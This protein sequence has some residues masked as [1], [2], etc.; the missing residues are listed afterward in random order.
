MRSILTGKIMPPTLDP[1][2]TV[3]RSHLIEYLSTD[4]GP[5]ITLVSAPIGYGKSVA[6]AKIASRTAG[7]VAWLTLDQADNDPAR[8]CDYL[9]ASFASAL[10]G[11]NPTAPRDVT[12]DAIASLVIGALASTSDR[13]T[14]I[15]D[16][17]HELSNQVILN[18]IALLASFPPDNFRLV[19]ASRSA[20]DLPVSQW[21]VRGLLR[22]VPLDAMRFTAEE[23][24]QLLSIGAGVRVE[25]DMAER[26]RSWSNGWVAALKM[27]SSSLSLRNTTIAQWSMA[28][29]RADVLDF[30][31]DQF[32][33]RLDRDE[34]D[35][36]TRMS[37]L[38]RFTDELS[39]IVIDEGDAWFSARSLFRRG[40]FI[41]PLDD[42]GEWYRFH[43]ILREALQRRAAE[44]LSSEEIARL[45]RRASAWFGQRGDIESAIDHAIGGNDWTS[46]MAM[47]MPLVEHLASTD[48]L[49]R[50]GEWL[51]TVPEPVI[52]ERAEHAYWYAWTLA[53]LGNVDRA[54]YYCV[55]AERLWQQAG[56]RQMLYAAMSLRA[57]LAFVGGQGRECLE[58]ARK[59]YGQLDSDLVFERQQAHLHIGLGASMSGKAIEAENVLNE[60]I[61]SPT[62][63]PTIRTTA[64]VQAAWVDMMLGHL[65]RAEGRLR[66]VIAERRDRQQ[67]VIRRAYVWL[68]D[69]AIEKERIDEACELLDRADELAEE[70]GTDRPIAD[71]ARRRAKVYLRNGDPVKALESLERQR[72]SH[73][74][75]STP[76][77]SRMQAMRVACWIELG[78]DQQVRQWALER[79]LDQIGN[80]TFSN[81]DQYLAYAR[82]LV[83]K[84]EFRRS[85]EISERLCELAESDGRIGHLLSFLLLRV[86]SEIYLRRESA[87]QTARRALQIAE[88]GG[89]AAT[90][91]ISDPDVN[92][93]LT[94]LRELRTDDSVADRIDR[95]VLTQRELEVLRLVAVGHSNQEIAEQLNVATA[96]VK[97]HVANVFVKLNVS[98]RTEAVYMARQLL[99]V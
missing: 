30:L 4:D 73:S 10:P 86:R 17:A 80:L 70:F 7:R 95:V 79:Q 60:L 16:D 43:P 24:A 21:R 32:I 22:E 62:T 64:R 88:D 92:A 78:W 44:S 90:I 39:R 71:T 93:L 53:G 59:S 12:A 5:T 74:G 8:F 47:M 48:R 19:L 34:I 67:D 87:E 69:I 28:S 57:W 66:S 58:L 55:Q 77:D 68:A 72:T 11:F 52:L 75:S 9:I 51:A 46:A 81:Q 27:A 98:S 1:D 76:I 6:A 63:L 31:D 85:F 96:T 2:R 84:G 40:F 33:A 23:T 35:F 25:P 54:A 3:P 26:L 91:S 99:F 94:Y 56:N 65:D 42:S 50:L 38:N 13:V 20:P 61:H 18:G 36:L 29:Y 49:D 83:R 41:E 15:L 82:W 45:H 89:Y 37:I 97:R 14:L